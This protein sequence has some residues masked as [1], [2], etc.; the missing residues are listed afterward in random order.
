[1]IDQSVNDFLQIDVSRLIAIAK[2]AYQLRSAS[3]AEAYRQAVETL[4][5]VLK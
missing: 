1:M 4:N 5:A 2:A 3:N